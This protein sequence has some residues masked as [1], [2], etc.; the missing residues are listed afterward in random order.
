LEIPLAMDQHYAAWDTGGTLVTGVIYGTVKA[1]VRTSV[2]AYETV[3]FCLPYPA[4][5]GPILPTL[6]SFDATTR[7]QLPLH[8]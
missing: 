2:G 7:S 3:T 8:E 6:R 5:Y 1:L 4:Q